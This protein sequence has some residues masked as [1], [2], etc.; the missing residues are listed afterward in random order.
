[1]SLTLSQYLMNDINGTIEQLFHK[2][3]KLLAKVEVRSLASYTEVHYV[4]HT[5]A[6]HLSFTVKIRAEILLNY[7]CLLIMF[8]S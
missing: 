8:I 3:D 1:M 6:S 5:F 7:L 4:Y 2:P